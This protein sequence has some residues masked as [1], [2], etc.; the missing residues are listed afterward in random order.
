MVVCRLFNDDRAGFRMEP[1]T[2]QEL[3]L[4]VLYRLLHRFPLA[5]GGPEDAIEN[6]C[7]L[8]LLGMMSLFLFQY[9][10]T[11]RLS[12]E[13]L[14]RRIRDGIENTPQNAP[15]EKN[16]LLWL[17][18]TSGICILERKER[19]W[20]IPQIKTC[21]STLNIQSWQAACNR[22]KTFPWI[23]AIYDG[24]GQELWQEV[25]WE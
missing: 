23:D 2:F 1:L 21:L 17:C 25:L 8:G 14:V 7:Y 24:P 22:I 5:D 13:L 20:L 10:R 18:F 12:Y 16:L 6:A 11:Q 4:S 3:I 19:T 15:I 9:G